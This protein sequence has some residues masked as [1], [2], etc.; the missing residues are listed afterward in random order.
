MAIPLRPNEVPKDLICPIC[1]SVPLEPVIVSQCTHVFC[2]SCITESLY[3]QECNNQEETCPVCRCDCTVDDLMLLEEESPLAYRIWSNITVKCEHHKEGCDWT[4]S[5]LDYP[6]H[7]NSCKQT[8]HQ[9]KEDQE[10]IRFLKKENEELKAKNKF[11]HFANQ[12]L[13]MRFRHESKTRVTKEL[14]NLKAIVR[15]NIELPT[16]N[17]KGGYAYDR[18]SVVQL[19][20][21][22]CQNLENKPAK[23]NP[24]KIFECVTNIGSDLRKDHP[25][26]PEHFYIDVRMLMGVCLASTWFTERQLGRI[27]GIAAENC[28]A[29]L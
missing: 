17:G 22:I 5:I 7:K 16:P 1:L 13:E 14:E 18:F 12:E 25:D 26:N 11:L 6:S 20:K 27:R 23:I 28:W 15:R 10:V 3:C 21:L 29:H 2:E 9:R 8:I 24:N 4:G 19:T